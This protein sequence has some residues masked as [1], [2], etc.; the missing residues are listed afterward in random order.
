[1]CGIQAAVADTERFP[2]E[3]CDATLII[4]TV[5]KHPLFTFFKGTAA[6]RYLLFRGI[7]ME[8]NIAS[9]TFLESASGFS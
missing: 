7:I 2:L 1:M 8:S 6:S 5:A 4:Y 9:E 3:T